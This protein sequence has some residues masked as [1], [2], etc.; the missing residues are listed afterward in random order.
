MWG[1]W[2]P[3]VGVIGRHYFARKK[4]IVIFIFAKGDLF[5]SMCCFFLQWLTMNRSND[6]GKS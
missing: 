1:H 2:E 6:I 4:V 5:V 3:I